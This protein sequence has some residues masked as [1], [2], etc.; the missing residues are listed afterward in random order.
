MLR[1]HPRSDRDRR[2]A[3]WPENSTV[4]V[5]LS[6]E[7]SLQSAEATIDN[8]RADGYTT[9]LFV[10]PSVGPSARARFDRAIVLTPNRR[11][12][13]L[14]K[15]AGLVNQTLTSM[16]LGDNELVR[17]RVRVSGKATARIQR[18]LAR[19]PKIAPATLN[20]WTARIAG[21]FVPNVFGTTTVHAITPVT[22]PVLLAPRQLDVTVILDSWD[23]PVRRTAGFLARHALAW[24]LDLAGDWQSYQGCSSTGTIEAYRL[25]YALDSSRRRSHGSDSPADG[26]VLYPMATSPNRANW[27]RA[28]L[29]LVDAI[30]MATARSGHRLMV[31]PKPNAGPG[32]LEDVI[33]PYDHVSVGEYLTAAL[34]DDWQI[35]PEYNAT[36]LAELDGA[37]CVI[38]TATTFALD[39]ASA[40]VPILQLDIRDLYEL[41]DLAAAAHNSHLVR[42]LYPRAAASLLRPSS[43]E[44]LTDEV[45]RLDELESRMVEASH[46][47]AT[48]IWHERLPS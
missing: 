25:K 1:R 20:R 14:T 22:T 10:E 3:G 34:T 4:A 18:L 48:W 11:I 7:S 13:V 29:L 42:H 35:T 16:P 36:R 44:E 39:A 21:P 24:N 27:Y 15:I 37:R 28:E 40:G 2:S 41:G 43:L 6:V 47:L 17:E 8:L 45:S 46:E 38:S 23:Q 5:Y 33:A 31:K 32:E 9:V 26:Y 12:S 30:C 19:L